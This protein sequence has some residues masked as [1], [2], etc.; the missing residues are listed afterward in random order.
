MDEGN[1]PLNRADPQARLTGTP[2]RI[3]DHKITR[4]DE[5]MPWR[6]A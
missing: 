3:P 4:L 2:G 5:P 1:I 6:Y